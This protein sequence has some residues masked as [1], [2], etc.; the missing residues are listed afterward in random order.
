MTQ[1]TPKKKRTAWRIV[2]IVSLALNVMVAGVIIGGITSGKAPR[3]FG[4][5]NFAFG[6]AAEALS[7]SDRRAVRDKLRDHPEL[8]P[9]R[10]AERSQAVAAFL[11]ALR[12]DPFDPSAVEALFEEQRT[13]AST[14]MAAVQ[15][16]M[17]ERFVDMT[18]EERSAYADRL[19][20]GQHSGPRDGGPRND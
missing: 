14:S 17:L 7:L 18:A 19:E 12:S 3:N 20:R 2:L 1:D 4:A 8:R 13:R 11:E 15:S 9:L 10:P 6:P 5:Q 16:A